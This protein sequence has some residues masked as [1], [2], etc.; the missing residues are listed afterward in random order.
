MKRTS[1]FTAFALMLAMLL[2]FA[3]NSRAQIEI[4]DEKTVIVTARGTAEGSKRKKVREEMAFEEAM[5]NAIRIVVN[6]MLRQEEDRQAFDE[7]RDEF[8][9]KR[10]QYVYNYSYV[11]KNNYDKP[12]YKTTVTLEVRINRDRIRQILIE[13]DIIEAADDVREE[14]DR[15][16]IMPYLDV[17]ESDAEALEY[18]DLFYTHVRVYFEDQ[19]IPTVGEQEARAIEM[20][21]ELVNLSK[22]SAGAEGEEDMI[23]QLSR[24]TPADIFVKIVARIESGTYGGATT[25]KVILSV[26]AYNAMTGEFIGSND[27]YSEPLALSGDQASIGAGIDQAMNMAMPKVMD[28]I[29]SFWRE[30][31]RN[32][33]PVKVIFTDFSFDDIR[34][35]REGLRTMTND[36]K[37]MTAAGNV[38]EFM[39]WY[40]GSVEDLMYEVYDLLRAYNMSLNEDPAIVANSIRFYRSHR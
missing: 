29:T 32:G 22:G 5:L 36:Q 6:D 28:R 24:N 40:D 38:A 3:A 15:F 7:V 10:D 9:A 14:L 17:M 11:R 27:G 33:R 34:H 1:A 4:L 20:D 23:L 2:G 8:F 19:N 31:L 18:K 21:E 35:I 26:G 30:Y 13:M 25:K 12:I 16:T 39:V 37:R